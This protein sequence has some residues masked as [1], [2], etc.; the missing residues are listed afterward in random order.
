MDLSLAIGLWGAVVATAV[1][2][3]N[4]ATALR[5]RARLRISAKVIRIGSEEDADTHGVLVQSRHG[6]DILW[7]EVDVELQI[8]NRGGKEIQVLAV[9]FETNTAVHEVK[10][11][12]L[13]EI[14]HPRTAVTFRVQPE[15]WA[16][17][18]LSSEGDGSNLVPEDLTFIG[19]VDALGRRHR[20]SSR[21]AEKI[22]AAC[23]ALPLRHGAFMH[24]E[25]GELVSAFQL[26][27]PVTLVT[28]T[29]EK[30]SGWR[31]FRRR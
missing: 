1:A 6:H 28:K 19:V 24:K 23:R 14:V 21:D 8:A 5:D 4:I 29:I 18:G 30:P 26:R 2:I 10:P 16:P 12:P 27:D 20:L 31:R 15:L 7:E 11:P 9:L 3:F 25:S 17:V 22:V 13:P